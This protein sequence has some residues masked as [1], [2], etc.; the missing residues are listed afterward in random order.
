MG[1]KFRTPKNRK[2]IG[3]QRNFPAI[4][5]GEWHQL[6]RDLVQDGAIALQ[7]LLKRYETS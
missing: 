4:S 1:R 2:I 5:C 3:A 6:W 7:K